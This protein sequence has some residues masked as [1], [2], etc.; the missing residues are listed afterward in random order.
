MAVSLPTYSADISAGSLLLRESREVAR[1]LLSGGDSAAW[2][3]ALV[4]DNVLQKRSPSSARRM[5]RLIRKRLGLMD[6]GLWRL[7]AEGSKEVATQ[8]LMAATVKDSRLLADF[9]TKVVAEHLKTFKYQ[10][11]LNDW[12]RFLEDCEHRDPSVAKWSESTRKK[13]GQVVI[14]ILSEAGYLDNTRS[15]NLTPVHL[16]P[17]V[18]RFLIEHNEGSVLRCLEVGR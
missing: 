4:V 11:A 9:M 12:K 10:L 15:M 7:V 5:A 14:R 2:Y 13:V 17:E 1:L 6:S 16:V 3:Q 18:R 8:A